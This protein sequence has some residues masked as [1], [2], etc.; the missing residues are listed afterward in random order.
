[1]TWGFI[2]SRHRPTSLTT[3]ENSGRD[4]AKSKGFSTFLVE[5]I[6]QEVGLLGLAGAAGQLSHQFV[7]VMSRHFAGESFTYK[8]GRLRRQGVP[9][10]QERNNRSGFF[11]ILG[12]QGD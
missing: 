10:A 8:G 11:M 4:R 7:C 2:A 5:N 1:M 3:I 12:A 6:L 9:V